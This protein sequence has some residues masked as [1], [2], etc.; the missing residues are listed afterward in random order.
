MTD[1]NDFRQL[2]WDE[3]MAMHHKE[4]PVEDAEFNVEDPGQE[5]PE[6]QVWDETYPHRAAD[7]RQHLAFEAE[8]HGVY[9]YRDPRDGRQYGMPSL[10]NARR[11]NDRFERRAAVDARRWTY[12]LRWVGIYLVLSCGL[13]G[14]VGPVV[15]YTWLALPFVALWIGSKRRKASRVDYTKVLGARFDE[16]LS[17]QERIERRNAL[18]ATGAIVGGYV[19]IKAVGH[20]LHHLHED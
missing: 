17:D 18:I 1:T 10:K 15:V 11:I 19:A 12:A 20:H 2:S 16:F 3:V 14:A 4:H 8:S 5:A 7:A 6:W 9:W 13:I